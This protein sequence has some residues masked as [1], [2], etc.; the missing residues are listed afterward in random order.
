M[1]E[2]AGQATRDDPLPLLRNHCH[3][4]WVWEFLKHN[5]SLIHDFFVNIYFLL[6]LQQFLSSG[7]LLWILGQSQFDKVVEVVCPVVQKKRKKKTRESMSQKWSLKK[8]KNPAE[9]GSE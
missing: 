4:K 5:Y 2:E 3:Q 8:T 6:Y 7:P 1:S 9:E